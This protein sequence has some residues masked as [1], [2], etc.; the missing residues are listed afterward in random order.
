MDSKIAVNMFRRWNLEVMA[1]PYADSAF[2]TNAIIYRGET[3]FGL[4][5]VYPTAIVLVTGLDA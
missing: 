5:V 1:N 2:G 4:G 3:R